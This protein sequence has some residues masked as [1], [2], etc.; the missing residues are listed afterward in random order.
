MKK[1]IITL[2]MILLC[3]AALIAQDKGFANSPDEILRMLTDD[4]GRAFLK[5]EFDTNSANISK[6]AV[7]IVDSLGIALTSGVGAGMHVKLVGHTDSVGK[8]AY[9]RKLSLQRAEAV[10]KYL[11]NHFKVDPALIVAEGMG[12]EKPIVPNTTAKGR[13]INRRVEVININRKVED[14]K[15]APLVDTKSLW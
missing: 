7:P 15:A 14:K 5:I 1:I 10:K 8:R 9:N 12:E 6:T 11:Q 4:G 13:A 2:L 3:P